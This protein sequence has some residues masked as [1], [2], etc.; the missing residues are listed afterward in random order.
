VNVS[1]VPKQKKRN[2]T[3]EKDQNHPPTLQCQSPGRSP[4]PFLKKKRKRTLV[5]FPNKK[6]RTL[7]KEQTT[8]SPCNVKVQ[9]AISKK[10]RKRVTFPNKQTRSVRLRNAMY[11][12]HVMWCSTPLARFIISLKKIF[13]KISISKKTSIKK[14]FYRNSLPKKKYPMLKKF[15]NEMIYQKKFLPIK[16]K[17]ILN[18]ILYQKRIFLVKKIF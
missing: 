10:K 13:K 9:V 17:K 3:H 15:T 11:R 6:K 16:K 18:E 14:I 7:R 5:T 8:H 1:N 12:Y 4:R 2:E